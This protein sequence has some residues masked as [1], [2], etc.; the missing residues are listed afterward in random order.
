MNEQLST[1][2]T[3]DVAASKQAQCNRVSCGK[4][5]QVGEQRHYIANQD[6]TKPGKYVCS[7]CRS[8]Y[9]TRM[10]TT[11]RLVPHSQGQGM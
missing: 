4:M 1:Q 10:A 3:E 8:F 2:F 5:I 6:Y 9:K 7:D 11:R